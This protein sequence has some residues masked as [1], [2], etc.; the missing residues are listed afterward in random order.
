[1]DIYNKIAPLPTDGE[2]ILHAML[3][4]PW[5]FAK[6]VANFYSKKRNFTPAAITSRMAGVLGEQELYDDYISQGAS[7]G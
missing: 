5:S 3:S 6:I 7:L 2:K 4:F 1:L